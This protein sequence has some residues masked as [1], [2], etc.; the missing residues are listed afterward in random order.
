L[1][2]AI[3]LFKVQREEEEEAIKVD[4]ACVDVYR[5]IHFTNNSLLG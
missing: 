2:A 4:M 1:G 3:V 5:D